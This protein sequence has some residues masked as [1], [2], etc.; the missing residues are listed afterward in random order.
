MGSSGSRVVELECRGLR[1]CICKKYL[2]LSHIMRAS[3]WHDKHLVCIGTVIS[4]RCSIALYVA[5]HL[6]QRCVPAAS[7]HLMYSVT[8]LDFATAS[9]IM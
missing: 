9:S 5:P 3:S 1:L 7:P 2:G 6:A 8:V 4:C